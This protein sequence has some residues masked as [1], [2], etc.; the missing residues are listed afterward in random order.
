MHTIEQSRALVLLSVLQLKHLNRTDFSTFMKNTSEGKD[1][2]EIVEII[3][4]DEQK[5][6]RT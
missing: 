6:G 1:D 3:I 2:E 5:T 4:V